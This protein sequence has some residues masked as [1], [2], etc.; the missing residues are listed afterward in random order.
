[1]DGAK[2]TAEISE[3]TTSQFIDN[4]NNNNNNSQNDS[5]IPAGVSIPP[6]GSNNHNILSMLLP[7][8]PLHFKPFSYMPFSYSNESSD[9][10]SPA[11]GSSVNQQPNTQGSDIT[12]SSFED[13]AFSGTEGSHSK[14]IG[15]KDCDGEEFPSSNV[16][17][18]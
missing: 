13:N 17:N 4:N 5:E 12:L 15:L 16:R 11:I 7:P 6:L 1:M 8:S 10:L 9:S 3:R 14:I 2:R 18:Y